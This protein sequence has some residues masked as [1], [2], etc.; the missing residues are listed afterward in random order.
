MFAPFFGKVLEGFKGEILKLL[1]KMKKRREQWVILG[2]NRKKSIELSKFEKE[3]KK[4]EC[5][6]RYKSDKKDEYF[7]CPV[8]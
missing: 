3:M 6:V 2:G 8:K 5:L 7:S 1:D 4:L